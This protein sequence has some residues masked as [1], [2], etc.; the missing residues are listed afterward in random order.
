[1]GVENRYYYQEIPDFEEIGIIMDRFSKGSIRYWHD[2][3]HAVCWEELGVVPRD[4]FLRMFSNRMLGIHLHDVVG[5]RDH[6]VPLSGN[7]DF[8]RLKP[9][10]SGETLKVVEAF[11][12]APEED[13][14]RGM[15]YIQ[16]CFAYEGEEARQTR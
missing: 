12:P 10:V 2:V 6:R 11:V 8:T 7:F 3:G 13:V 9:Y 15:A 14:V 4:T 5:V 16:E 1:M